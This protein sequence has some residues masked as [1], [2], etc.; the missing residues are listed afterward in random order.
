MPRSVLLRRVKFPSST[1]RQQEK[2][3]SSS[4]PEKWRRQPC[5][6]HTHTHIHT[7]MHTHTHA[8]THTR[9]V[10]SVKLV[11]QTFTTWRMWKQRSH[12]ELWLQCQ[13]L[14]TQYTYMHSTILC[15]WIFK[16]L[17]REFP[18]VFFL[19]PVLKTWNPATVFF[20]FCFFS[21]NWMLSCEWCPF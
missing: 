3:K 11:N 5:S 2:L 15:F 9:A 17:T 7:H 21:W 14:S 4:C 20:L 8:R 19:S 10:C 1:W 13:A 12:V 16:Y 6:A 18:I